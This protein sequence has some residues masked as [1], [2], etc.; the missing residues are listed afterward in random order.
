MPHALLG[1]ATCAR[2]GS[3]TGAT[4]ARCARCL[5]PRL[6]AAPGTAT[7]P[8]QGM[9][10]GVV[11]ASAGRRYTA[12]VLD[13]APLLM[14]VGAAAGAA[15][16]RWPTGAVA[17]MLLAPVAF[18][19][20]NAVAS[21]RS[22]QT[23]GRRV[24]RL[25]TVDDLSGAPLTA[26]DRLG[27]LPRGLRLRTTVTADLRAGRDPL[28]VAREPVDALGDDRDAADG[29]TPGTDDPTRR[30][31]RRRAATPTRDEGLRSTAAALILDS[32]ES[33][34]VAA[35]I[36]VGRKPEAQVDGVVHDVHPWADLSRSVA[37]THARFSWSGSSMWITDLGS[38]SGTAIITPD[39][40]RRPLVARVPTAASIGW[41]VELGRRRLLI[42]PETPAAT[43]ADG[44]PGGAEATTT[45]PITNERTAPR[46]D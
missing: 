39:G 37:R 13:A 9:L 31:R 1:S 6:D 24:L 7:G 46:A 28:G 4:Q 34:L 25:R 41:T 35:P 14:L 38:P 18:V 42:G 44:A 36:V 22:G 10:V 5:S 27:R 40:E 33:V 23:L 17:L 21:L 15:G 8:Y 30:A 3:R 32:G 16:S 12:L 19:V 11:P 26:M 43:G 29:A 20:A 45:S 2:C